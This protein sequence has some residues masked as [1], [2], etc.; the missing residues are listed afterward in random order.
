MYWHD[1]Q[2]EEKGDYK[3]GEKDGPWVESFLFGFGQKEGDYKN[4][5]EEGPWI[6]HYET[7]E[8]WQ[9]GD[10]KDGKREGPWVT[11]NKDGTK[12]DEESGIYRGG[13]KIF[14]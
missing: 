3:N 5:L 11:Y 4:G 12:D 9:K 6:W 1:G 14:D 8:L 13:K 7:G 2:L 10:Y